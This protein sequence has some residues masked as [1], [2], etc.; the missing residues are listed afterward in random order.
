[1]DIAFLGPKVAI[2]TR[3]TRFGKL[4]QDLAEVADLCCAVAL[5]SILEPQVLHHGLCVHCNG[6]REWGEGGEAQLCHS[7][8]HQHPLPTL[9]Q[10]G[11][12]MLLAKLVAQVEV[13]EVIV[14]KLD[15]LLH[16]LGNDAL[17]GG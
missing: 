13:A 1:M 5:A 17:Q 6:E 12:R 16:R 15:A 14:R 2:H 3:R 8:P 10:A 11:V 9:V 7:L 4:G